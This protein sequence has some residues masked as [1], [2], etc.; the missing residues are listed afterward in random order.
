[1]VTSPWGQRSPEPFF[2]RQTKIYAIAL[3]PEDAGEWER[4]M[5]NWIEHPEQREVFAEKARD[6]YV[7]LSW[8]ASAKLFFEKALA[9]FQ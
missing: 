3:D 7:S 8:D 1:M 9:P 6:S 4:E 2:D 5:G